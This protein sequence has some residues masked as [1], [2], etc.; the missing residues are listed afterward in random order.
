MYKITV[1][2]SLKCNNSSA[3][4]TIPAEMQFASGYS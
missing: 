2:V 4:S 1:Y 3:V